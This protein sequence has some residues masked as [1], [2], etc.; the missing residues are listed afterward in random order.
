MHPLVLQREL[1]AALH[2]SKLEGKDNT[3]V[4][5]NGSEEDAETDDKGAASHTKPEPGPNLPPVCT[6]PQDGSSAPSYSTSS[7]ADQEKDRQAKS[8]TS[9][10]D[11]QPPT[12]IKVVLKGGSVDSSVLHVVKLEDI[13]PAT[14]SMVVPDDAVP[15]TSTGF[16]A[17]RQRKKVVFK[18][19]NI[20]A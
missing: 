17:K 14:Q 20:A 16:R 12:T 1:E 8:S 13:K 19:G 18:E 3:A 15:S 5:Q 9:S 11:K 7:P 4:V 2:I 6:S 10:T